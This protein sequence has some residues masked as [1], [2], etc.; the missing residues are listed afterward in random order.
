MANPKEIKVIAGNSASCLRF[1]IALPTGS[2]PVLLANKKG[3]ESKGSGPFVFSALGLLL[4]LGAR[5]QHVSR[6]LGGPAAR[7]IAS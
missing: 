2:S 3:P 6:M 1:P 5:L 4:R 7:A